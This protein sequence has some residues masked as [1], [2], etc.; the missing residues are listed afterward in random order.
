[1][2]DKQIVLLCARHGTTVLN[3]SGCFRGSAN[4]PLDDEGFRDANVSAHYLSGIEVGP[5]YSSPRLRATQTA[6]PIAAKQNREFHELPDLVALDVGD[7]SGEPKNAEN[8]AKIEYYIQNPDIPIPGGESLNEFR[9]RVRPIFYEALAMYDMTGLPCLLV[10]HSSIIHELGMVF[11]NDHHSAR[12]EPG[13]VS[14]VFCDE[15][16]FHAE[17]IFKPLK[18][19]QGSVDTIS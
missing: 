13:G 3:A 14:A 8:V 2:S 12:V 16:E 5:I 6:T 4:P 15:G 10:V 1:M 19:K 17:P 9:E 7:F 18:K 11:N